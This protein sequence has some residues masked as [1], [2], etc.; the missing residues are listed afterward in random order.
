M[1]DFFKKKQPKPSTIVKVTE[2]Q[3]HEVRLG[4]LEY[5]LQEEVRSCHAWQQRVLE[6]KA[7]VAKRQKTISQLKQAVEAEKVEVNRINFLQQQR[8]AQYRQASHDL[9]DRYDHLLQR[10]DAYV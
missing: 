6:A 8:A 10:V 7:E 1:F 9:N 5:Q 3:P 4:M 2:V